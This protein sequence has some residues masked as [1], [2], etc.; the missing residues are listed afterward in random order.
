M[1][2]GGGGGGAELDAG[3]SGRWCGVR[4]GDLGGMGEGWWNKMPRKGE[5]PRVSINLGYI[6]ISKSARLREKRLV[7]RVQNK[8]KRVPRVNEQSVVSGRVT[9]LRHQCARLDFQPFCAPPFLRGGG[10]E[11]RTSLNG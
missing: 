9:W 5:G 3:D 2:L 4:H 11:N 10:S 6:F 8:A 1:V 7:I